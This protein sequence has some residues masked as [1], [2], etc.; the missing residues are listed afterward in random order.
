ML[1]LEKCLSINFFYAQL[2]S[3][4]FSLVEALSNSYLHSLIPTYLFAL[5]IPHWVAIITQQLEQH[6]LGQFQ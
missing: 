4:N 3:N 2:V 6:Q 5:V 1:W